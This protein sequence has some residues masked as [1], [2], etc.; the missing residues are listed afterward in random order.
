MA[1]SKGKNSKGDKMTK[2]KTTKQKVAGYVVEIS[3]YKIFQNLRTS[4]G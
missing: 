2:K 4:G 3:N 1:T